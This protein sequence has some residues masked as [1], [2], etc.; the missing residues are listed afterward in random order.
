MESTLD[1]SSGWDSSLSRVNSKKRGT[2]IFFQKCSIRF[3]PFGE[4]EQIQFN[5][6]A[7]FAKLKIRHNEKC[8]V[9]VTSPW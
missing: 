2:I 7:F 6:S 8:D 3:V 4:K 5:S 1:I 9:S